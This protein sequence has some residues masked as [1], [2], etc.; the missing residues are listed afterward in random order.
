MCEHIVSH[1]PEHALR[2]VS[3]D[4]TLDIG[5]N[6]SRKEK[7]RHFQQCAKQSA[8]VGIGRADHRLDIVGNQRF[9][10]QR[11]ADVCDCRNRNTQHYRKKLELVALCYIADKSF[12]CAF[13]DL[14]SRHSSCRRAA[15]RSFYRS[16]FSHYHSPL[17]FVNYKP[18]YKL[19]WYS[20]AL[21]ASRMLQPGRRRAR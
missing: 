9:N 20:S 8:P 19:Y 13:F 10:K 14:F 17:S 11:R 2:N 21:H 7:H 6:N 4:D 5:C 16:C 15:H 12:Q 3:H 18:R 1:L